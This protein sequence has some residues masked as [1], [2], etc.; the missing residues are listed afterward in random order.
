MRRSDES[1]SRRSGMRV[2]KAVVALA[3]LWLGAAPLH[4]QG[5]PSSR[6]AAE[7]TCRWATS[8]MPRTPAI[9]GWPPCPSYPTLA[10]RH[11][12]RRQLRPVPRRY[13]ARRQVSDDLRH[14]QHRLQVQDLRTSHLPS[15]PDR[16][17]RSV[18]LQGHGQRRSRRA[19]TRRPSS[20]STPAPGSTSRRDARRC[21]PKARFHD[22]FTERTDTHYPPDHRRHPLRRH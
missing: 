6:W 2:P 5:A 11:P 3:L 19:T 22:V 13:P 8:T 1:R 20:A 14:R 7:S 17:R 15:L 10:G 9:T 18:Q 21:S 16:R 4:A 12:D